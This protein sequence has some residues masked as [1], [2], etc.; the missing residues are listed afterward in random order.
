MNLEELRIQIDNIDDQLTQ[1]LEAR[2]A[3]VLQIAEHKQT[4][5]TAIRDNKRQQIVLEK[6]ASRVQNPAYTDS[7]VNTYKDILKNSRDY[8]KHLLEK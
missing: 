2:M 4:T 5:G 6:V 7:I 8:Q 3:L 1:L